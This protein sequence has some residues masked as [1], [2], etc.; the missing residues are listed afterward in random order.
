MQTTFSYSFSPFL[1]SETNKSDRYA[2]TQQCA[3]I[4]QCLVVVVVARVVVVFRVVAGY[5][6]W[7]TI[8]WHG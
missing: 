7:A 6:K 3:G 8:M 4:V 1:S 5:G 2:A